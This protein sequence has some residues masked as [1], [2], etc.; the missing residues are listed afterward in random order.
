MLGFLSKNGSVNE[1]I[2]HLFLKTKSTIL[3]NFTI[4]TVISSEARDLF[5]VNKIFHSYFR[6][7]ETSSG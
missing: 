6:D 1:L 7:L 4:K 5:Q 3:S 2:R